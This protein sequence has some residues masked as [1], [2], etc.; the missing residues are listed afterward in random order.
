MLGPACSRDWWLTRMARWRSVV[1][2]P[3]FASRKVSMSSTLER[4]LLRAARKLLLGAW[5][6]EPHFLDT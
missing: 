3:M 5:P 4:G 6:F 1:G 2:S